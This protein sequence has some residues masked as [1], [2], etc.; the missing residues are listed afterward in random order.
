MDRILIRLAGL[1]ELT[2]GLVSIVFVTFF[3]IFGIVE[4]PSA[5]FIFVIMSAFA[6]TAIGFGI[7]SYKNW[8]RVLLVFF[9][10]Y[11]IILKVLMYLGVM[12]FS[13]EILSVLPRFVKDPISILYHMSLMIF[14]TNS[15]VIARFINRKKVVS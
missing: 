6:S 3:D 1:I 8:A 5:V 7:L 14:L 2:I 10:G 9:S 4:K 11:V 15:S 13:G 12:Q